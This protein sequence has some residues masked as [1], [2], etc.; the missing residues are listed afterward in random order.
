MFVMNIGTRSQVITLCPSWRKNIK[1]N[2]G[3]F[4]QVK[5]GTKKSQKI[6]QK[7][8]HTF[9]KVTSAYISNGLLYIK[10]FEYLCGSNGEVVAPGY[11]TKL[12]LGSTFFAKLFKRIPDLESRE[13]FTP[14]RRKMAKQKVP[15]KKK[16]VVVEEE[17]DDVEEEEEQEEDSEVGEEEEGEEGEN[18]VEDGATTEGSW[19]QM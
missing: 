5:I 16:V 9:I 18:E 17:E 13:K 1:C 10:E 8:Q 3:W 12:W 7:M 2:F 4:A 14:I 19:L 6:K 11:R 15:E